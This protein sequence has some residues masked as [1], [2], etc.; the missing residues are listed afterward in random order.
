MAQLAPRTGEHRRRY[1][2]R[3]RRRFRAGP[4]AP[5]GQAEEE[6]SRK[7][8]RSEDRSEG[9]RRRQCEHRTRLGVWG[10]YKT[11]EGA[12]GGWEWGM[13]TRDGKRRVG[14]WEAKRGPRSGQV[15]RRAVAPSPLC[16]DCAGGSED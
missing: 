6:T 13:L 10:K 11:A 15:K 8:P 1:R 16:E 2:W 14:R 7:K 5:A 4:E 12:D 3:G 9:K